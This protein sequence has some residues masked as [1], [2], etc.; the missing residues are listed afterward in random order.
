MNDSF[1]EFCSYVG[2][3]AWVC[4]AC[5][6]TGVLFGWFAC[7]ISASCAEIYE[8]FVERKHLKDINTPGSQV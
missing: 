4:F 6:I 2:D 3:P 5:L 8:Y 7:M 1:Y